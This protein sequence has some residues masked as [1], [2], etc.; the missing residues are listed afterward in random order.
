MKNAVLPVVIALAAVALLCQGVATANQDFIVVVTGCGA[1][2]KDAVVDAQAK[3][4]QFSPCELINSKLYS[5]GSR[6]YCTL[7]LMLL[8]P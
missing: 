7:E 6:W 5:D 8:M 4:A 1:T 3:A 2:P